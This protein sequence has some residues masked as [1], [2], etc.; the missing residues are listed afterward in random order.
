MINAKQKARR[1]VFK[2]DYLLNGG[3]AAHD[4]MRCVCSFF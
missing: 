4:L 1:H 3:V 2:D